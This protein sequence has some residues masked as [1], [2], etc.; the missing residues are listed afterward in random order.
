MLCFKSIQNIL[1]SENAVWAWHFFGGVF[2]AT[3]YSRRRRSVQKLTRTIFKRLPGNKATESFAAA[4][5][6]FDRELWKFG[7]KDFVLQR[8]VVS[9]AIVMQ[10]KFAIAV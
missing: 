4:E 8:L 2:V 5:V 1:Y 9:F 3:A 7:L 10:D 6:N